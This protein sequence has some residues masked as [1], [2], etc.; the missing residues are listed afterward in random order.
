MPKVALFL[1]IL[2]LL[3]AC[4]TPPKPSA[5]AVAPANPFL[6]NWTTP[7]GV[8]PFDAIRNEH[9]VPAFEEGM[10]RHLAE[11]DAIIN[12]PAAPTF[13]NT[14]EALESSGALL[15]RVSSV[16]FALNGANTD[17]GK[18]AIAQKMAPKL[19]AHGDSIL[20]NDRLFRRVKAVWERKDALGLGPEQAMLLKKTWTDFVRNGADLTPEKKEELKKLNQELSTLTVQF[21]QNLLKETNDF[22]LVLDSREDLAGL[23]ED[24]VASSAAAAKERGMEGKWVFTL[25]KPSWIPFL[26]Y[27]ERR[28]LREKLYTAYTLRGDNNNAADNK[29]VLARIAAL[30]VRKAN[31]LGFPTYAGWILDDNMAKTP[32]AVFDLLNRLWTPAL[33][34]GKEEAA[35]LKALMNAEGIAGDLKPS[36]WWYYAEKLR[37][38]KYALDDE[39]LKPYFKLENVIAGVFDTAAKLY[40][41]RFVERKDLPVYHPDVR[42][43][44]VQE[45]DGR[46]IGILYTDYFPR[47]SKRAGAWMDQLR[48]Q[49]RRGGRPVLPVVFNVGNFTKPTAEKPSLLTFDEVET[50]F[51]EFGH[52]LHGLLSDCTYE[53]TSGTNVATDFVELPSQFMESFALDP[54]V[55]ATYA[56]HYQTGKPMPPEMVEKIKNSSRFNQ[57]FMSTEYLAASLLDMDWHTLDKPEEKDSNAFE[58]AAL[59]RIGLIPEIV[60][61]YRSPY[62]AHIFSGGYAAGYYSYIWA[63]VLSSDAFQAFKEKGLFDPST[64]RAF[65]KYILSAGGTEEP[66]DLY[67]KFRGSKPTIEP[68]LERRGLQP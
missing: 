31:L 13:A 6:Q 1:P 19:S 14:I 12:D 16:F 9:F 53:R 38:E 61:R 66:M 27:S 55:I 37:K 43:F 5:S 56:K 64:A 15:T 21:G 46:T 59:D 50:L 3:A 33:T 63:E 51:H 18:E 17:E 48:S 40:G 29:K 23:T 35:T 36:D 4:A 11:I 68:L 32:E 7:F 49:S 39:I 2:A 57:G 25:D 24:I 26:Q 52:A 60:S 34:K 67:V 58:K 8:P 30:R 65:R 45:A 42:T 47:A 44:E 22:A 41:I 28:D 54:Q 62:F 20:L 10:K